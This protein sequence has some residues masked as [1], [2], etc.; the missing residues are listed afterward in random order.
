MPIGHIEILQKIWKFQNVPNS[1]ID[2]YD[3]DL[4]C[5][6]FGA[7][8]IIGAIVPKDYTYSLDYSL[9]DGFWQSFIL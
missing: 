3:I 7:F 9:F 1:I 5:T 2:P 6:K 4:I 8:T